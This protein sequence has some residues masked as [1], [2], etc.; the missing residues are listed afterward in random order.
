M[1]K[2]SI[3]A[4]P[5]MLLAGL[6]YNTGTANAAVDIA[7][8]FTTGAY[9]IVTYQYSGAV[10][11]TVYIDL[12]VKDRLADGHH[13]AVRLI[14]VDTGDRTKY[15]TWRHWYEGNNTG[16]TYYTT[17]QLDSGISKVGVQ[18]GRFEGSTLLNSCKGW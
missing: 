4:L 9:G 7:D 13:V 15:W 3:I 6:V 2:R 8:C 11:D 5:A 10:N 12:G 17:A 16:H 1:K 14:T 18:V